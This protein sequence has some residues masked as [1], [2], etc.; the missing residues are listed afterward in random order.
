MAARKHF[1][2]IG[3]GNFGAALASRL[4]A[5]GCRVTGVDLRQDRV[6]RLKDVLYEAVIADATDR[7]ALAEL[8][9]DKCDAVFVSLGD[10]V[11]ITASVLATLHARELQARR[12]IVKGSSPDHSK[13]LRALGVERVV[14]PK[15]EMAELLADRLTWPNVL[16]RM[17]IDAEFDIAE[18]AVPDS[19]VGKT[20][21]EADLIRVHSIRVIGV[22]D[23]LSSR[24]DLFLDGGYRLGADQLLVVVARRNDLERFREEK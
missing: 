10:E 1:A 6:E 15:S 22:K 11:N 21:R 5:N 14:F 19:L 7:N 18:I 3:L 23:A 20:L 24:L 2:V 17:P 8:S 12:V 4:S 13:I 9:L 16:D